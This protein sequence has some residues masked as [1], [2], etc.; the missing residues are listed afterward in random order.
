MSHKA[1][2]KSAAD[3]LAKLRIEMHSA[4]VDT[5]IIRS[6][7]S[8]RYLFGFSGSAGLAIVTKK[9]VFFV[10]NDL[11]AEQIKTE[12]YPLDNL[13]II[14]ERDPWSGLI[15]GNA[16]KTS[17]RIGYFPALTTVAD[18]KSIKKAVAGAHLVEVPDIISPITQV[19]TKKEIDSIAK[20][21]HITSVAYEKML[22]WVAAGKTE[23]DVANFLATT[24]RELGSER[25]AFDIIVVSGKRGAMPHGRASAEKIKK[26]DVV[27]VDFGCCVKG[28]FS[29]MTRTFCIG[30][31]SKKVVDVFAVLFEAHLSALD[32]AKAG[33]NASELDWS[34]RS[35]IENRGYGEYFKHSLGHGLGY[36]VHEEPR[37]SP[38]NKAGL[39]QAG[40]V[41][42]IEPGIYLPGKF[43]MRIE[44][45]VV[46]KINGAEILTTAPREL[47]VV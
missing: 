29:D 25:D 9:K 31:P 42:T 11:Y 46:V 15:R 47:V 33:V 12:L 21:A 5:L 40:S 44:D 36:E 35:I 41:I 1:R 16:F 24:T 4:N 6:S 10:T 28:F 34:A 39:V 14:I 27:T 2:V 19:K 13:Q 8:L 17:K 18:L 22:G 37:I 7:S 3:R 26:G 43:G 38:S 30:T 32:T 23:I 20:A 45:D